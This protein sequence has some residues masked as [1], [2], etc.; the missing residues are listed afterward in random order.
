MPLRALREVGRTNS[1][2]ICHTS[3][4]KIID[5]SAVPDTLIVPESTLAMPL[6]VRFS[7]A[8]PPLPHAPPVLK[9]DVQA[10]TVYRLCV[11]EDLR[12]IMQLKV[13][14]RK[15]LREMNVTAAAARPAMLV[16]PPPPSPTAAAAAVNGGTCGGAIGPAGV[17]DSEAFIVLEKETMST[18]RDWNRG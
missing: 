17:Y 2:F 4:H 14:F 11:G 6:V 3:L 13:T 10:A 15:T 12:T 1:A 8:A 7:A 5:L 16:L 18:S 9:C